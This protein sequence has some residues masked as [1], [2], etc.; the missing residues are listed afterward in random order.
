MIGSSQVTVGRRSQF[1]TKR[2]V[3]SNILTNLRTDFDFIHPMV[4]LCSKKSNRS[5]SG[6]Y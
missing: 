3:E 5:C 1:F 6:D 4:K 2:Y